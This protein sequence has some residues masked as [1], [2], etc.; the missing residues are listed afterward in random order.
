VAVTQIHPIETTLKA[1]IDYISNPE[2]TDE[3]LLV[4]GLDCSPETA[5]MQFNIAKKSASKDDGILAY[6]MIQSFKPGE[7]DFDTAHEI[8]L[9]LAQAMTNGDFQAVVSTHTDRGH[10]HNHIIFNSVSHKTHGKFDMAYS[11]RELEKKSDELC[12]EYG[13]SVIEEKSGNKGKSHHEYDENKK[14]TSWK[15]KLRETVDKNIQNAQNWEEFLVLMQADNYEIKHGKHIGFRAEEQSRFIRSKTLGTSYTEE[16][17]RQRIGE[18]IKSVGGSQ[19][20][21]SARK[22]TEKPQSHGIKLLID[23][24]NNIKMK[25]SAGLSQWAMVQNNKMIAKTVNYITEHGLEDYDVLN[26][27]YT[28]LKGKRDTSLG[29][30]KAAE[31][32]IDLLKKQI[33]AIDDYRKYKPVVE[34]IESVVFKDKYRRE[35]E[36]EFILFNAAKQNLKVYFGSEKLPKIKELREEPGT[37]YTE[38]NKMYTEYYASKEQLKELDVIKKNVDKILGRTPEKEAVQSR[39]AGREKDDTSPE[40]PR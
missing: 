3:K 27:K 28:E 25:E 32:R 13:L 31:S 36:T 4:S 5:V 38:K 29:K 39:Q 15:Q 17:I 12:R 40:R 33:E 11:A 34:G 30:I 14:G 23:I 21:V 2:K 35:H 9:K 1:A 19:V 6:H 8:G 37:L 7:V 10:T 24:E 20:D 18:R 16:E 26:T 22:N